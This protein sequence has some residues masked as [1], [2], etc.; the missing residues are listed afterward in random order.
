MIGLSIEI[1]AIGDLG[2]GHETVQRL[3]LTDMTRV[4]RHH[5]AE[6]LIGLPKR[7]IDP[8][9][10]VAHLSHTRDPGAFLDTPGQPTL[11]AL[12]LIEMCL[13]RSP[14]RIGRLDRG[15]DL[16][17]GGFEIGLVAP[18]GRILTKLR[19]QP[20]VERLPILVLLIGRHEASDE[21]AGLLRVR[22]AAEDLIGDTI[23]G[24]LVL[25][26]RGVEIQILVF[27]LGS[28]IRVTHG[29]HPYRCVDVSVVERHRR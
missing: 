27:R 16:T 10:I 19:R 25:P 2:F 8:S 20:G 3:A 6:A 7:L 9:S 29:V 13:E 12:A 17:G 1:E 11:A 18:Q 22:L 28:G 23:G 21:R 5:V 15:D 4:R 24:R 14:R 26:L